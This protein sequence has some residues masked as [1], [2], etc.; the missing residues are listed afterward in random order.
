MGLLE[1][2]RA[3]QAAR[4]LHPPDAADVA[5]NEG[6]RAVLAV[7]QSLARGRVSQC[8][9]YP[10]LRV[11]RSGEK[12][13]HEIDLFVASPHGLAGLEVKSWGGQV[14]EAPGG[15][16]R[17]V[18]SQGE[19]RDHDDPLAAVEM[20]TAAVRAYLAA[21]GV[22]VPPQALR[23]AVV[24]TNPRLDVGPHLARRPQLVRLQGLRGLLAPLLGPDR[25]GLWRKLLRAL[26][27]GRGAPP[28]FGN[29]ADVL[30]V[31]DR[32][33]TWDLVHLH[34]G[35]VLKG[36]VLG[37]GITLAGGRTL[38]RRETAALQFH[39]PRS[40]LFG[41]FVT[42]A[43]SWADAGGVRRRAPVEPGQV[44]TV[45][46]AGRGHDV[47]VPLEHVERVSFGWKDQAY[48][49]AGRPELSSYRPGAVYQGTVTG[50]QE[51]GVFVNLDG[52]RDGLVH[53]SRLRSRQ[54][55]PADYHTGQKVAV[56]VVKTEVRKGKETIELDLHG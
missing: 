40:W 31:L 23:A 29:F 44:I 3:I 51:Y 36:D 32:L 49:D 22:A 8:R 54:R 47:P 28:A 37:P 7:V 19:A 53:I 39:M 20:K 26:G 24:L 13:K 50:I 33:P 14:E 55:S 46:Q 43:V 15:R 25:G 18:T 17:Q 4:R 30:R 35:R 21:S 41:W 34:G 5:G 6:E 48:Y 10:S 52:H 42:P 2:F 45:R 9:F 11:P 12:G 38:T 56:R 27:V 1:R 16:W